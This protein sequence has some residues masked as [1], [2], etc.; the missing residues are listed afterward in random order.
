M[1]LRFACC[2]GVLV[3]EFAHVCLVVGLVPLLA[4]FNIASFVAIDAFCWLI[5]NYI[6]CR[7]GDVARLT[8]SQSSTRL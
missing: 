4:A 6:M 5:A 1:C 8:S 2:C 3:Q 7:I